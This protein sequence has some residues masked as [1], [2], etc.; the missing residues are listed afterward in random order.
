MTIE[1]RLQESVVY[2]HLLSDFLARSLAC[3]FIRRICGPNPRTELRSS[4]SQAR[5]R[6]EL[7]LLSSF[8][9]FL[10]PLMSSSRCRGSNLCARATSRLRRTLALVLVLA[11]DSVPVVTEPERERDLEGVPEAKAVSGQSKGESTPLELEDI[12]VSVLASRRLTKSGGTCLSAVPPP[13][14]STQVNS[15]SSDTPFRAL[16]AA[17]KSILML[18]LCSFTSTCLCFCLCFRW[19]CWNE[20]KKKTISAKAYSSGNREGFLPCRIRGQ[21]SHRDTYTRNLFTIYANK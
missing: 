21:I 6:T 13:G 19:F 18:L 12:Y 11:D 8:V 3:S 2:V 7:S 10:C 16:P 9:P 4:L 17:D 20:L 15:V 1:V 14:K 5:T